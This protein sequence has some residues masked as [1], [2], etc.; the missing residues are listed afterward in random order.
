MIERHSETKRWIKWDATDDQSKHTPLSAAVFEKVMADFTKYGDNCPQIL[1]IDS[2]DDVHYQCEIEIQLPGGVVMEIDSRSSIRETSPPE[3]LEVVSDE[4]AERV[5][6][7][8]G[9]CA[10]IG[11][12]KLNDKFDSARLGINKLFEQWSNDRDAHIDLVDLRLSSE[13]YW[14]NVFDT[15]VQITIS[16]LSEA[17]LPEKIRVKA[18]C[19]EE[20]VAEVMQLH[21][22]MKTRTHAKALLERQGA[23][24]FI[25]LIAMNSLLVTSSVKAR[26]EDYLPKLREP[27]PHPDF[28]AECGRLYLEASDSYDARLNWYDGYIE[29]YDLEIPSTLRDSLLGKPITDLIEH[30][31]LTP[32]IIIKDLRKLCFGEDYFRITFEQP[33]FFYSR[34]TGRFW[35]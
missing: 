17:L 12:E 30:P 16:C 21:A 9:N 35:T 3:T 14:Q 6:D 15:S 18:C 29:I 4:A 20:A 10:E 25:D 2:Y 33:C 28:K 8:V 13:P 31:F 7:L 11:F 27:D 19:S 32:E 23:D 1:S 26:P 5:S 34:K 24:G 22:E